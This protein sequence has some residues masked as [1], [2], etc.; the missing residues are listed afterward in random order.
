LKSADCR[1]NFANCPLLLSSALNPSTGV[2]DDPE[3][4]LNNVCSYF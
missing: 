4:Y 3:Q 2:L 1:Q